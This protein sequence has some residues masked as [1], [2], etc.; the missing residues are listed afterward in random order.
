MAQQEENNEQQIGIELSEEM[1]T[2]AYTNLAIISHSQT[3]FVFDFIQMMPGSPKAKV[4]SRVLMHPIHAKRL[5]MALHDNIEKFEEQFG[6]IEVGN[7][8]MPMNFGPTGM[9]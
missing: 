8:G 3:E 5:L 4:R 7:P 9:A 6:E 2:G 1:A